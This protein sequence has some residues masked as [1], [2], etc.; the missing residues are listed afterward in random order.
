MIQNLTKTAA[1]V[2][3]STILATLAVNAVDMRGYFANTL[4]GELFLSVYK[5]TKEEPCPENMKIVDNA[6]EPF[7]VDVYE[8]SPGDDCVYDNPQN[9]DE[10]TVNLS[11]SKCKAVS[12]LGKKP[13]TN[14]TMEQAKQACLNAGKRLPNV[15]EWY[16]SAVGT[17]DKNGGWNEETCNVA[18]NR[19]DGVAGTGSGMRCVSDVGAYDMIG[20]VWEWTSDIVNNGVLNN[21]FLPDTGFVSEVDFSGIA[22]KTDGFSNEDFAGDRFWLDSSIEAGIMRGGYYGS[23]TQAGVYS[24]YAA[25]PPSFT[26]D[27]VGFRCVADANTF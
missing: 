11:N 12:K 18:H 7:C 3:S 15:N 21:Q 6:I 27:A 1:V 24:V 10:S 22:H 8:S 9:A 13:W 2:V 20:N 17:P 26:G 19:E 25:S 23:E 4:L 16:K 14:I 5:E